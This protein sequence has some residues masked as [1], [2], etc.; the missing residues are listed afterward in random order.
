MKGR[1]IKATGDSRKTT[2]ARDADNKKV[3]HSR[4]VVRWKSD[5]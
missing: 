1:C 4:E 5:R 2:A 3:G